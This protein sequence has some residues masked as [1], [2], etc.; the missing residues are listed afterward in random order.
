[1]LSIEDF[2][3]QVREAMPWAE[4]S[5]LGDEVIITC[6]PERQEEAVEIVKG[7]YQQ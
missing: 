5:I 3:A 1:M 6:P 7:L 4:V 2:S